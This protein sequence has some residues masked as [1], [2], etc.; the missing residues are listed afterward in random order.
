[1]RKR[2]TDRSGAD[3]IFTYKDGVSKLLR[4]KNSHFWTKESRGEL[5]IK[6]VDNGDG[7][8]L[9][10]EGMTGYLDYSQLYELRMLLNQEFKATHEKK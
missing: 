9:S 3:Y 1:M 6:L 2:I 4:P 5:I 7:A 8:F 10:L